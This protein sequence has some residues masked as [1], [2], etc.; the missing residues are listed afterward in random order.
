LIADFLIDSNLNTWL[1][2]VNLSPSLS[3]DCEVDRAVKKTLIRD[4]FSLLGFKSDE[5]NPPHKFNDFM[6]P[7]LLH[8]PLNCGNLKRIFPSTLISR[9]THSLPKVGDHNMKLLIQQVTTVYTAP[10]SFLD[11]HPSSS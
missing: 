7:T 1:L 6:K 8:A 3:L 10:R 2:E 5:C 11:L 4:I 9:S